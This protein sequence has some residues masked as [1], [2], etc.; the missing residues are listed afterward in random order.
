[1]N[2]LLKPCAGPPSTLDKVQLEVEIKQNLLKI[3]QWLA[4]GF[5]VSEETIR[6]HL[7]NIGMTW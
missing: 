6:S 3:Y 1:M 5:G 4:N 7:H 2:G